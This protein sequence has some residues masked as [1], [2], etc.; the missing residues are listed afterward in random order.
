MIRCKQDNVCNRQMK[1]Q[2]FQIDPWGAPFLRH[3]SLR[4][5]FVQRK[6]RDYLIPIW[7]SFS[8]DVRCAETKRSFLS[9]FRVGHGAFDERPLF[10]VDLAGS[11]TEENWSCF[12]KKFSSSCLYSNIF[13]AEILSSTYEPLVTVHL[14]QLSRK[15]YVNP[16][17]PVDTSFSTGRD[18]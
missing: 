5:R 9:R 14:V 6:L 17:V 1:F 13:L 15:S 11:K 16:C 2:L 18:N 7:G 12:L 10:P 8:F 3:L 4:F